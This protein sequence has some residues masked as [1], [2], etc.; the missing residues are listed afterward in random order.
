[1]VEEEFGDVR[2]NHSIQINDFRACRSL[3][4]VISS[5]NAVDAG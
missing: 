4:Q 1:M 5:G 2:I 3:H